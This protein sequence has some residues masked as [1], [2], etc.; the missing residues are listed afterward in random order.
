MVQFCSFS[1]SCGGWLRVARD[2]NEAGSIP[3]DRLRSGS[4]RPTTA[5]RTLLIR[6][7]AR[8]RIA[9]GRDGNEAGDGNEVTE[10]RRRWKRGGLDSTRLFTIAFEPDSRPLRE[11]I[12]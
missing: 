1:A 3:P 4:A 9:R 10:A 2:G 12:P 7:V 6:D 5:A 8:A 11:H